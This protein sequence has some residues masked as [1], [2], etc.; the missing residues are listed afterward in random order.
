MKDLNNYIIERLH[1]NKDSKIVSYTKIDPNNIDFITS[2]IKSVYISI[3]KNRTYKQR[4]IA[5]YT[6]QRSKIKWEDIVDILEKEYGYSV[7][8]ENAK[9]KNSELQKT[10]RHLL[11]GIEKLINMH[12]TVYKSPD[13]QQI[14]FKGGDIYWDDWKKYVEKYNLKGH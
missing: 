13:G 3:Y 11:D 7:D 14:I 10:V 2:L 8:L 1:I 6:I 12:A 4:G 5:Q 9:N